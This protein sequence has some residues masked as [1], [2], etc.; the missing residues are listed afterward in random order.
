M[1]LKTDCTTF[2]IHPLPPFR[3]D[4]TAWSLQRRS[5]NLID[6]WDGETYRRVLV[7]GDSPLEMMVAQTGD[8]SPAI[9][10][11]IKGNLF[12]SKTKRTVRQ[13]VASTFGA[14]ADLT[15]FYRLAAR[16]RRLAPLARRFRGMKPPR[17]FS[18]FEGLVNGIACQQLSLSLGIQLLNRLA[19]NFGLSAGGAHSLSYAFP[20]PCDLANRQPEEIRKLGFNF[21]KAR[22]IIEISQAIV[23]GK[24]NLEGLAS[25]SDEEALQ[26]LMELRGV[27]RWTAEYTL[28][29]GMGRW[30]VFP[31]DDQGARNGLARWLHLRGPLDAKR[32]QR[33][34]APWKRYGGL[35]YFYMLMKGLDETG[36]L[37]LEP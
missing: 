22:A 30:H 36:H 18:V 28:L 33:I 1:P 35:I 4:L 29:R 20:R 21:Q 6:R 25:A 32:A 2:L 8:F 3:L 31:A 11:T 12:D 19:Q 23:E 5:G 13:G 9:R 24:L 16:D 34:L 27:G 37:D 26:R 14:G 15:G 10:V 7:V 17:F